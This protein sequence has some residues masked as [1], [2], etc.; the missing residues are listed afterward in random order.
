[1]DI[2]AKRVSAVY[3]TTLIMHEEVAGGLG[4]WGFF[5]EI[6]SYGKQ[7]LLKLNL[8][9]HCFYT[10]S[11]VWLVQVWNSSQNN[12]RRWLNERLMCFIYMAIIWEGKIHLSSEA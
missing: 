9:E 1:M 3:S 4:T 11:W 5:D 10:V 8:Q 2:E 7:Q 6:P 12:N